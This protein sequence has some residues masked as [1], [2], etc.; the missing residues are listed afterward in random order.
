MSIR[1]NHSVFVHIPRTG[2]VWFRG[3]VRELGMFN[4]ILIGDVDSHLQYRELPPHW[5]L[6]QP[7]SFVRHPLA[8]L[9]S[10]WSHAVEHK[11]HT[12]GTFFGVH[13]LFDQCVRDT[14]RATVET[15]MVQQPGIVSLTYQEMLAGAPSIILCQTEQLPQAAYRLLRHLEA[16]PQTW[17]AR[18]EAAPRFN[19][20]ATLDR[21]QAE[22]DSLPVDLQ[23]A[24]MIAERAAL[25]L[26]E[27]ARG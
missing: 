17:Q 21:Y 1:F 8:W 11:T 20:T 6:L 4:H 24:F 12:E 23:D 13:L 26:W 22:L 27:S 10:R 2:G 14:F 18:I 3:V 15:I 19:S 25:Q 5:Q 7:F 16:I 9:R